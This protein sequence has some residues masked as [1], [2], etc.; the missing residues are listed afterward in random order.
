MAEGNGSTHKSHKREPLSD[1]RIKQS[2]FVS[3][4]YKAILEQ[5]TT[6]DE[7]KE[8]KYWSFCAVKLRQYDE[9]IAIEESGAYRTHLLVTACDRNWATVAV[10]SHT[11]LRDKTAEESEPKAPTLE[12]YRVAYR[13][14]I[15]KWRVERVSDN[16]V[17]HKEAQTKIEADTWL[18]Q[19]RA[20]LAKTVG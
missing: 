3:T 6:L 18:A 20:T 13:G 7:I 15:H 4:N 12:E 14:P 5:G 10:I 19:H 11:E 9:I 1:A 8:P 16:S 17:V 2:E